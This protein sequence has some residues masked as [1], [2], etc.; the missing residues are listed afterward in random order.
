MLLWGPRAPWKPCLYAPQ[1]RRRLRGPLWLVS[2]PAPK[3][4]APTREGLAPN[5]NW[6]LCSSVVYDNGNQKPASH[7]GDPRASTEF[8]WGSTRLR[9]MME[10]MCNHEMASWDSELRSHDALWAHMLSDLRDRPSRPYP[11]QVLH[12]YQHTEDCG[13]QTFWGR[14]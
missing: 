13:S 7:I 12:H 11:L 1:H 5:S 4:H 8:W 10:C 9:P 2:L 14:I 6:R 3:L